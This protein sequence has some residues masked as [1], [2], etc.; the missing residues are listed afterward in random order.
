MQ[1]GAGNKA[2]THSGPYLIN[3]SKTPSVIFADGYLDIQGGEY[4]NGA[5]LG[6]D[7]YALWKP[8]A[9]WG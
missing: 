7:P 9:L 2:T 3:R 5:L 1:D 6:Y 8:A 4:P